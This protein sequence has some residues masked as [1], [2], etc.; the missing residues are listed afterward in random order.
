[1]AIETERKLGVRGL[2]LGADPAQVAEGALTLADGIRYFESGS[3]HSRGGRAKCRLEWPDEGIGT[4]ALYAETIPHFQASDRVRGFGVYYDQRIYLAPTNLQTIPERL[5]FLYKAGGRLWFNN[6]LIGGISYLTGDGIQQDIGTRAKVVVYGDKAYIVDESTVPKVFQRNPR[7]EQVDLQRVSYDTRRMGIDWPKTTSSAYKPT[8]AQHVGAAPGLSLGLYRFRVALENKHG[9][10][11]NS[12]LPSTYELLTGAAIRDYIVVDWSGLQAQFPTGTDAVKNVRLYCQFTPEGSTQTEASAYLLFKVVPWNYV[13]DG[14]GVYTARFTQTLHS[15]RASQAAMPVDRGCPPRLKDLV[16]INDTA[17][18]LAVPDT[19]YRED[20][21]TEGEQR[22]AGELP[23]IIANIGFG[24]RLP[25]R[26]PIKL[27]DNTVIKDIRVDSSYLFIGQPG[28]P[29]HMEFFLPIGKGTEIGVGLASLGASCVIFTNQAIYVCSL[30][31][32]FTLRRVPAKVGALSRDSIVETERGI[33]FI[34]TDGVPRLFNGATVD[35][36]ADELLPIFDRDDYVGDYLPFDRSQGQEVQ[37]T[38]GDR[39][40]FM[41]YPVSQVQGQY[42]PG[43][44]IDP[45]V[46]RHMAVGDESR[47]PTLW[48]IDRLPSYESLYWLGRESRLLA[49]DSGG[50]FYFI[51]EGTTMAQASGPDTPVIFEMATRRQ[52]MGGSHTQF[53][54]VEVDAETQGTTVAA[55]AVVDG[56]PE[57]STA[58]SFSTVR[59]DAVLFLLPSYFK[60]RYLDLQIGASTLTRVAISGLRVETA[61]RGEMS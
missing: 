1:M 25:L 49:I 18:A 26:G 9:V 56:V 16:I 59:R 13:G 6:A 5:N 36:V 14:D 30:E 40:F 7:A 15:Q 24:Y 57:L 48:S 12:C 20:I 55:T 60:G 54:A 17:F 35:E 11:S 22:Y 33:R 43:T 27:Y 39:K 10:V 45:G 58:F 47:G 34:G 52:G 41:L 2:H 44:A 61:K 53:Y 23:G 31:P 32:E 46:P 50:W 19:I 29:E 21:V 8:T 37:G 42:K 28:E 4:P 3:V 51:E 38:Y